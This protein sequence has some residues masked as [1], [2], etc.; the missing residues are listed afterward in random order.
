VPACGP[1]N[2]ARQRLGNE[3]KRNNRTVGRGVFHA[4]SVVSNTQYVV[5]GK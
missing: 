5:K 1:P 4:V 2:V 3:Y